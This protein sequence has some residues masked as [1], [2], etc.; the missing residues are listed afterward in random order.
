M[1]IKQKRDS[2]KKSI[3]WH[4]HK[5]TVGMVEDYVN[6]LFGGA[7]VYEWFNYSGEPYHFKIDLVTAD[8]PNMNSLQRI[9]EALFIIKNTRSWCDGLGF[10]RILQ[11]II[12]Y[13]G[14]PATHK[15]IEIYP[16]TIKDTDTTLKFYFN[17]ITYIYK[18][19][20]I[21]A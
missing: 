7:K 2:V 15:K 1:T 12:Y 3:I 21:N 10:L 19:V 14:I 9:I 13:F 17:G 11:S 18:E 5:G 4:K 20:V 16:A 8:I 6:I